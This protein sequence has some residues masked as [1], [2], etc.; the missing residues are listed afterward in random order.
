MRQ[1]LV[2]HEAS[3]CFEKENGVSKW[4]SSTLKRHFLSQN[5][6]LPHAKQWAYPALNLR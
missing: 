4:I 2:L 5:K 1:A 6:S 3:S